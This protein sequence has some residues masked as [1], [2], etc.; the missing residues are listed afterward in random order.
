MKPTRHAEYRIPCDDAAQAQRVARAL[1][2]ETKDAPPRTEVTVRG[3][4]AD[5]V[6]RVGSG[7]TRGLRAATH[8][9]LRWAQTA[10]DVDRVATR[11]PQ[12]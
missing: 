2:V 9:F 6:L 8:S 4:G 3:E 5:L 12:R 10:L 11:P 7:D 1:R